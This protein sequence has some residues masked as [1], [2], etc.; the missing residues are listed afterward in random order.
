MSEIS[1]STIHLPGCIHEA[2]KPMCMCQESL[3]YA[4]NSSLQQWLIKPTSVSGEL[5][6]TWS[7][8]RGPGKTGCITDLPYLL[9]QEEV[10]MASTFADKSKQIVCFNSCFNFRSVTS[11]RSCVLQFCVQK[12]KNHKFLLNNVYDY[13]IA[14]SLICKN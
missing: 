9:R 13:H 12:R 3:W 14:W 2:H 1:Y 5:Y 11:F 7:S 6:F 10:H 8:P 4:E